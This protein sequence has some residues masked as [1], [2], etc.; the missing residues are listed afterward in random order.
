MQVYETARKPSQAIPRAFDIPG[1]FHP[2]KI[3]FVLSNED[4]LI[5]YIDYPFRMKRFHC[6]EFKLYADFI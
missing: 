1:A 4:N 6:R 5:K 3:T 2:A